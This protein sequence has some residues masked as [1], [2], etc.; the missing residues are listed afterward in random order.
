MA[1]GANLE[2]FRAEIPQESPNEIHL[3]W[4]MVSDTAVNEFH[5]FRKMSHDSEFVKLGDVGRLASYVNPRI[6]TYVDRNV[7]KSP[8][9][10][11]PVQ[12]E[13]RAVTQGGVVTL[14]RTEIN[15]TSTGVRRTWGS[16]K[17]MFQ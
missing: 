7:F 14:G 6:Y 5:V 17:S 10:S 2:Y 3:E 16:I 15:Y 12:Y 1:S 9:S 8:A 13:L 4:R 11:E